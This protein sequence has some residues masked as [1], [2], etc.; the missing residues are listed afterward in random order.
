MATFP[1]VV[2]GAPD[3]RVLKL[4][5]VGCGGRGTGAALQALKADPHTRLVAMADAFR[6]RG[7]SSREN[8]RAQMAERVD[9]PDARLFD[10]FD[11]FRKVI[12]SGVDVVLLATPP[13]FRPQ[14]LRA[15]VEAGK[16]VFAEKPVAVDGPGVRSVLESTRMAKEKNTG[17]LSGLCW[18]YETHTID[19][20]KRL[21]DGAIG[22]ITTLHTTRFGGGVWT[23]PKEPGMTGMQ[24]QMRNWYYYTWLSGDFIVEQFVHELDRIAWVMQ[25]NYPTGCIAT[26]G[27]IN[28]TGPDHGHIYDHFAAEFDYEDG[29]KLFAT[30]RHQRGCRNDFRIGAIGTEGS[31]DLGKFEITGRNAFRNRARRTQMHQLEHDAF[32]G[33]LRRG[34]IINNGEYMAKSTLMAIMAR[35]SAYTGERLE[36]GKVLNSAHELK[37]AAYA[38]DAAPPPAAVAIPGQAKF[39]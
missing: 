8:L 14:H 38:W 24:A 22:D 29:T 18:R 4:G 7:E 3:Q 37:P 34:E 39:A 32:F 21:H 11:G 27:R 15:C 20:M 19:L 36:W 31:C 9:V 17:I 6:E 2:R 1:A 16:H 10:G 30:T 13:H 5:L 26:G 25:D 35:E 23:R 33:A 28:R 12:D